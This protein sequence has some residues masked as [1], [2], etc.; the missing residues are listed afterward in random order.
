VDQIT[1]DGFLGGR[2]CVSQPKHGYRAATDPVF[3]AA[4]I[5][6]KPGQSVLELG[7]GVGV[8]ALCL[9]S[10]IADLDIW[11]LEIQAD[12]AALAGRNARTNRL[13]LTVVTGDILELPQALKSQTFD[14]VI[15][16]PPYFRVGD[17]TRASDIGKET[18]NREAA[19]LE[20]WLDVAARRVR[21]RGYVTF[22]NRV[23]RLPDLLSGLAGRLGSIEIKPIAPRFGRPAGRV[24]V[25]AR[26]DGREKARLYAPLIVHQ[27]GEHEIDGK[28]YSNDAESIL[29]AGAPL[30]F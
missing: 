3:L 28:S 12:Y 29:S 27:G 30:L 18:A 4:S 26:K 20:A 21:P 24:L 8:A 17:G 10:R 11:G 7:C 6:A 16:N 5:V 1:A 25:R 23:D 19:P 2:L 22:I 15:A 9:A 13:P 14:H